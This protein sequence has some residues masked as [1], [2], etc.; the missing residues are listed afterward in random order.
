[1][2]ICTEMLK[3]LAAVVNQAGFKAIDS[4]CQDKNGGSEL[5][6]YCSLEKGNPEC[7]VI[8]TFLHVLV[9]ISLL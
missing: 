2:Q 8:G 1:M 5:T 9:N 7:Y 6:S 4:W 3:L